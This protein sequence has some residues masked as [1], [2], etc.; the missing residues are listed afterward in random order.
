MGISAEKDLPL[1]WSADQGVAWTTALP[2]PGASSPVAL[3]GKVFVTCYSGYG[4]SKDDPG[5][6]DALTFHV[7]CLDTESGK[8]LWARTVEPG[9]RVRPYQGFVAVHGYASG[10]PAADKDAVYAFFGNT[11]V[12]AW[13]HDGRELWRKDVGTG[14]HAWGSGA[15]PML[16]RDLVIVNACPESGA[17]IALDRKTGREAWRADGI[18]QAWN[19]P[20]V[21]TVDGR[22]ELIV[23]MK[24]WVKAYDPA[25]GT[26]LWQCEGINDYV[27]P[28]VVAD[29]GIVYAIGGRPNQAVAVR[30]GG[31]GDVTG[32]H[33]L[34]KHGK[35]SNNVSSPV[36][37]DGHLYW[38]HDRRGELFCADANTGELVYKEVLS[39]SSPG[40]Y[41]SP[42][43]AAG[44]IYYVAVN[45]STYVVP[46]SPK[47]E[48]LAHNTLSD[49]S[50]FNASPA[51]SDGCLLLRSDT[52]L[53]CIGA[54]K[55]GRV[56][57]GEQA[58]R[59]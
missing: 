32:T 26:L 42:V 38:A 2:G 37:H 15:S 14:V 45:G 35:I 10:T 58:G 7:V 28:G 1:E 53:H 8:I 41:A 36:Y 59:Q 55:I 49:T 5:S 54:G 16:Y 43:L 50:R 51:V 17:L 52:A 47:F 21:I 20:V 25:A 31:T 12:S 34:W 23:S 33:K 30:A 57:E 11:G 29:D 6:T 39:P 40:F 9:G 13:T 4:L 19:T 3:G 24:D 27:C 48:L 46:A 56:R 22:D 18:D 44:R